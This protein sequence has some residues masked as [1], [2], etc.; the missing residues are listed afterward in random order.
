VT[1]RL[2]CGEEVHA[3][4]VR[5]QGEG[6]QVSVDGRALE[7]ILEEAGPGTFL[8]RHGG[9]REL[10]HCVRDGDM[11][12]LAW[13]GVTYRLEHEREGARAA[14]RHPAGAL[15]APMPGKVTALRVAVGQAV[16]K[17][18]EVLV[19]EAMKMENALRAPRDGTVKAVAV[20]VGDMV[21]PGVVLVELE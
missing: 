7:F 5:A 1:L 20:K 18:E 16:R 14:S 10:L 13:R 2:R 8:V 21:S 17:G 3:V 19:V 6:V 11:V 12:H 4:E 15:E 9:A